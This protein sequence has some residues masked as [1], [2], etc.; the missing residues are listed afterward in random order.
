MPESDQ[1]FWPVQWGG[2]R[3]YLYPT[4]YPT[5]LSGNISL[6]TWG[7]ELGFTKTNL[8]NYRYN[9]RLTFFNPNSTP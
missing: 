7:V 5:D 4:L 2:G 3:P 9:L 1:K 6:V 8:E